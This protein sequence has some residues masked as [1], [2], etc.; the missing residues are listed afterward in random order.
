MML[1]QLRHKRFL[2]LLNYL[3]QIDGILLICRDR[4]A[5]IHTLV[6]FLFEH[7]L[8]LILLLVISP[9]FLHFHCLRSSARIGSILELGILL[10]DYLCR[11]L[12]QADIFVA[13]LGLGASCYVF[14][15]SDGQRLELR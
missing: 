11:C 10:L 9:L 14:L 8:L 15:L 1:L 2:L 4:Y 7:Y 13:E 3:V 5:P 12:V 6:K